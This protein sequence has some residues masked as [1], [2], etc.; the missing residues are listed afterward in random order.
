VALP[1]RC[2]PFRHTRDA[3]GLG[4]GVGTVA[5]RLALNWADLPG[6]V[7]GPNQGGNFSFVSMVERQR[8]RFRRNVHHLTI[9]PL[10]HSPPRVLLALW[11]C[12]L[13]P[14][15]TTLDL[16]IPRGGLT[17]ALRVELYGSGITASKA[18]RAVPRIDRRGNRVRK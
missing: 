5:S 18:R 12:L 4:V 10:H 3:A 9:H 6:Q 16:V 15:L 8:C 17:E 7:A 14:R 2:P 13:Q 11:N 1:T